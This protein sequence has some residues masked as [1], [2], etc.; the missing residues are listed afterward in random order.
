MLTESVKSFTVAGNFYDL[1]N[2]IT[3]LANDLE[4]PGM[5]SFGSPTVRVD[6]L[7]VAGK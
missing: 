1:L 6:G 2:N 5:G 3:A 7:T 4:T